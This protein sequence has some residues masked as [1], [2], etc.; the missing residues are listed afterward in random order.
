MGHF[1]DFW[2]EEVALLWHRNWDNFETKIA[3]SFVEGSI[4]RS[5]IRAFDGDLDERAT[6]FHFRMRVEIL[7]RL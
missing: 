7:S 3:S 1:E 5:E 2:T 6:V 4:K